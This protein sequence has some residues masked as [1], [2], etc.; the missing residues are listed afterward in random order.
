[1][2]QRRRPYRGQEFEEEFNTEEEAKE[3]E[4]QAVACEPIGDGREPV[5]A[6][7]IKV[8]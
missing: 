1:M 7:R 5:A 4:K 3:R 2:G 8:R 6:R